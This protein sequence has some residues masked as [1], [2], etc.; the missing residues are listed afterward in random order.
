MPSRL[1][2]LVPGALVCLGL[3]GC[4]GAGSPPP[5]AAPATRIVQA[6]APGGATRAFD[7]G[8]ME[9]VRRIVDIWAD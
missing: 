6:V 8:C 7:G 5:P 9:S 2:T 1:P 4:A 3:S